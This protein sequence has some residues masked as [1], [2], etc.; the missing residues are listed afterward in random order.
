MLPFSA[1]PR[2]CI[3][4]FFARTEMQVHVMTVATRIR[5]RYVEE[6]PPEFEAGVNLRT[7]RDFLMWPELK[8]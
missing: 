1:G 6:H 3:G 5:L 2:N 8:V 4:E 7:K